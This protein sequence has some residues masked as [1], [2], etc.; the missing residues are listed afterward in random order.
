M[1]A[2][3]KK[4]RCN[5]SFIFWK[6]VAC[7]LSVCFLLVSDPSDPLCVYQHAYLYVH[8]SNHP[9]TIYSVI[10]FR[11]LHFKISAGR[12]TSTRVYL[13]VRYSHCLPTCPTICPS[14]CTSYNVS[15]RPSCLY[16][17]KIGV[18]PGGFGVATP[19]FGVEVEGCPR[20]IIIS[21]N[22]QKYKM[23]IL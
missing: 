16:V 4:T 5:S 20:T 11:W 9:K 12:G 18:N 10:F 21:Y 7:F 19:E 3:E 6:A 23:K 1:I 13:T 14:P 15:V 22:V 17:L 8:S 2:K